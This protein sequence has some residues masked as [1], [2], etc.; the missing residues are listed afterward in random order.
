MLKLT[1]TSI[2]QLP[3]YS[4]HIFNQVELHFGNLPHYAMSNPIQIKDKPREENQLA[5]NQH[6]QQWSLYY[7]INFHQESSF[8]YPIDS[9][10]PI[11]QMNLN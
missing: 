5:S 2:I 7:Q 9:N 4:I 10:N 3:T 1:I 11:S 8:S 6:H